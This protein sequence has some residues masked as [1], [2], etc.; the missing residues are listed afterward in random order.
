VCRVMCTNSWGDGTDKRG[1]RVSER[2]R[3]NKRVAL[4]GRTHRTKREKGSGRARARGSV[5]TG[6]THG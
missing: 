5:P 6:E 1:P 2:E 4:T 3:A